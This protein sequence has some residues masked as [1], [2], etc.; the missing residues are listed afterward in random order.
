MERRLSLM[1]GD[2]RSVMSGEQM[3]RRLKGAATKAFIAAPLGICR[4]N[5]DIVN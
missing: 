1:C 3:A 5:K 4:S 2:E